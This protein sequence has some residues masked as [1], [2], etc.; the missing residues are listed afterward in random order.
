MIQDDMSRKHAIDSALAKQL[1][2][3]GLDPNKILA[4]ALDKKDAALNTRIPTLLLQRVKDTA[5]DN[6]SARVRE[7]IEKGLAA[8]ETERK[9]GTRKE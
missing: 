3:V 8:E 1:A 5:G 2:Q 9:A 7:L 4:A 6:F